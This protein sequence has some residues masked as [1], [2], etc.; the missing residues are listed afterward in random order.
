MYGYTR[1]EIHSIPKIRVRGYETPELIEEYKAW[2]FFFRHIIGIY[3]DDREDSFYVLHKISPSLSKQQLDLFITM[4]QEALFQAS[5]VT[6][7]VVELE[8]TMCNAI[9]SA[10]KSG[11]KLNNQQIRKM[12]YQRDQKLPLYY[13]KIIS[14][15][16]TELS[17]QFIAEIKHY[18][19]NKVR[20]GMSYSKLDV[21][22]LA[23]LR[24]H[25]YS[26]SD[27]YE[28]VLC[29]EKPKNSQISIHHIR[30]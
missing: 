16:A 15:M 29:P 10:V 18:V 11:Q 17:P 7:E 23:N 24:D 28:G 22:G 14:K 3:E 26:Y 5:Y 9:V 21:D 1:K 19:V 8:I 12:R 20:T 27:L 30:Q 25:Q 13:Q 4:A 6:S 2:A